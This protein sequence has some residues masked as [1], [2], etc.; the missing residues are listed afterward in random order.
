VTLDVVRNDPAA[1]YREALAQLGAGSPGT[2]LPILRA[3][4]GL[5]PARIE[6]QYAFG[7]ACIQLGDATLA[8][9]MRA[10]LGACHVQPALLS[11]LLQ[12]GAVFLHA[13]MS[14]AAI[15]S[16]EV[17]V[18]KN[19][20]HAEAWNMLGVAQNQAGR[21]DLA[22]SA[23]ERCLSLQPLQELAWANL[24]NSLF[25]TGDRSRAMQCYERSL[26]ISPENVETRWNR[27]L[28]LLALGRL[29]EGLAAFEV[30]WLRK[31]H[32]LFAGRVIHAVP[33]WTGSEP[34]QGR[35]ILLYAEQGLGDTIQFV[36]YAKAV[37][38]RGARVL[39]EIPQSLAS[40]I[41]H[42]LGAEFTVITSGDH[43]GDIDYQCPLMSLPLALD[44]MPDS[45]EFKEPYLRVRD[46]S[47]EHW[48]STLGPK[49][50]LRAGIIWSGGISDPLRNVPL[51]TL[52]Q[53]AH[54]NLELIGLQPELQPGDADLIAAIPN[55]LWL[56]DQIRD[57]DDTA[58]LMA[59]CDVII[60]VDTASAH[61][62]GALG[63]PSFLMLQL[64]ADWR[65]FDERADSP[66]YPTFSIFR[67][68]RFGD[69]SSVVTNVMHALQDMVHDGEPPLGSGGL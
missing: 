14:Q 24:G 37:K 9:G 43:V 12:Q 41:S 46:Q 18:T 39:I 16:F 34:I 48:R 3:L 22:V 45:T 33:R 25:R 54:L 53:F 2:A 4:H 62:A 55:L 32:E 56:G 19:P 58:A 35:R 50:R 29:R 36:R 30:R 49:R 26:Q 11:T 60:T 61:L 1:A 52:A 40:L 38:E 10:L 23:F 27:S 67:Q 69:W 51:V 47:L 28:C 64:G 68:Q 17:Y 15:A 13:R 65:W 6:V 66:W 20:Q 5:W 42:S 7:I 8:E 63:R 44:S 31:H 57:F 21:F 59:L